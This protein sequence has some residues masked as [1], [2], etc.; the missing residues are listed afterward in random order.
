MAVS[1]GCMGGEANNNDQTACSS[2]LMIAPWCRVKHQT[3]K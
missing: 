1:D 3:E 2:L